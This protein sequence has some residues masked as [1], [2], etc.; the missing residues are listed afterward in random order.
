MNMSRCVSRFA[1]IVVIV[2]VLLPGLLVV[3]TGCEVEPVQDFAISITPQ[4]VDLRKNQSQ[5]FIASGGVRYTWSLGGTNV[6]DDAADPWGILSAVTGDEVTYTSLRSP[7]GTNFIVR[8]LTVTGT[9]GSDSASNSTT[10]SSSATAYIYH[11]P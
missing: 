10:V 11:V 3:I 4:R 7:S 9:L 8:T 2:G 5:K 6:A 1:P